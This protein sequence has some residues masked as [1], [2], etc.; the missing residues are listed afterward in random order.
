M[1]VASRAAAI[2]SVSVVQMRTA[3]RWASCPSAAQNRRSASSK[4]PPSAQ[5]NVTAPTTRSS[6]RIG[7]A[8]ARVCVPPGW[9]T[10]RPCVMAS[11]AAPSPDG[12]DPADGQLADTGVAVDLHE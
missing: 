4:S 1:K 5:V 11:A 9:K 6:R 7:N 2:G 8:A 10:P 3:I 12:P